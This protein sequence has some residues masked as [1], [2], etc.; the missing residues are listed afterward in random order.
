MIGKGRLPI[1]ALHALRHHEGMGKAG[2]PPQGAG[3]P[4]FCWQ[5]G[6]SKRD[7]QEVP[8]GLKPAFVLRVLRGA[9]APLFHVTVCVSSFL[10]SLGAASLRSAAPSASVR[11]SS[12]RLSLHESLLVSHEPLQPAAFYFLTSKSAA[13]NA[14]KTTEITPFMVKK[15]ALSL[16]RSPGLTRECS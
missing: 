8:L 5:R 10:N 12:R 11:A 14:A 15:A 9:E 4:V 6:G 2:V 3:A 1:A 13:T 7:E 16:E